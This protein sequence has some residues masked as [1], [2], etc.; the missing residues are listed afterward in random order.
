MPISSKTHQEIDQS[1]G[2]LILPSLTH[3]QLNVLKVIHTAVTANQEYPT[4]QEIAAKF[5]Y[6]QTAAKSVVDALIKKGYLVKAPGLARRNIRL[7][8]V[9]LE[10]IQKE[11]TVNPDGSPVG[12]QP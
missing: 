3:P 1:T 6:G 10:K 8:K 5:G 2:L 7:T 4:Q 11:L 12:V 9:A